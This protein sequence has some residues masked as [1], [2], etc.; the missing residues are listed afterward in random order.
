VLQ[1]RTRFGLAFHVACRAS[2]RKTYKQIRC[3]IAIIAGMEDQIVNREQAE[4]LKLALPHAAIT[5]VPDAG[6]MLHYL[7]PKEIAQTADIVLN[8][9]SISRS[10]TLIHSRL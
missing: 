8:E 5:I 3:P 10:S 7:A 4:R 2:L 1:P 6:H 9:A